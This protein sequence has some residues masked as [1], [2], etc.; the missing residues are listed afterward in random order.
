M[1]SELIHKIF[2]TRREQMEALCLE[3]FRFQYDQNPVYQAF[4]N[5]INRKPETVQN[6]RQIP[7]LP[8]R[9]FK[10]HEIKTGHYEPETWFESSGTTGMVNSKH[11]IRSLDLYRESFSRGFRKFYGDPADWCILGLLPSY[12]ER[13][14]SSLV[15]MVNELM[16]QSAHPDNGFYL[17][18]HQELKEKLEGLER[19]KQKTLLFGVTFALLDFAE[20]CR[21]PLNNTVIMET[22]GMKG[23]RTEITRQALHDTLAASFPGAG[24]HSEYGMTELLSQAY[25]GDNGRFYCPQWMQILLREEDDPLSLLDSQ[26]ISGDRPA[27]GAINIIDLA[28]LDSCCFLATD[29]IGK[30]YADGGFEVLGRLDN[31]DIRGCS[32]LTV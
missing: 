11:L 14:H 29:D 2:S 23:R 5:S 32:L 10:T 13:Q 6:I 20:Y 8:I 27:S 22:G 26:K 12:L 28:N 16:Q 25:C 3:I 17:Y 31:S 9:F 7:F 30:Q 18:N 24:I 21:L 1:R 19:S 15:V 4:A